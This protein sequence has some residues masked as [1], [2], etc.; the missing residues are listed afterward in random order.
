MRGGVVK[1]FDQSRYYKVITDV[2]VEQ[3]ERYNNGEQ[4]VLISF[5]VQF[6]LLEQHFVNI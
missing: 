4:E 3:D 6:S 1:V 2:R 5:P